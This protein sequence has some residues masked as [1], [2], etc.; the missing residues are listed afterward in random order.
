MLAF[1]QIKNKPNKKTF[2]TPSLLEGSSSRWRVKGILKLN[3][4]ENTR[5]FF[6]WRLR[7]TNRL[8]IYKWEER[9]NFIKRPV[10]ALQYYSD[11]QFAVFA[12]KFARIRIV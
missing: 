11:S 8:Q 9:A 10:F 4:L 1:N 7:I 3:P 5:G 2:P 12:Y 6:V